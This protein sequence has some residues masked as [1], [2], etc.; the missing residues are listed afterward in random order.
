MSMGV[1]LVPLEVAAGA[2]Q[3]LTFE[4]K[5]SLPQLRVPS[6]TLAH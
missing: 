5:S 1:C 4:P 6:S 3:D 2:L